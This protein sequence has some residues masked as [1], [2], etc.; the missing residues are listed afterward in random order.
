MARCNYRL[1][2]ANNDIKETKVGLKDEASDATS[3]G[4]ITGTPV[5]TDQP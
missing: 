5:S 3:T 4:G 1:S 2:V